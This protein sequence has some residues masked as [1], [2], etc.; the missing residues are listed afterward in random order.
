MLFLFKISLKNYNQNQ[1]KMATLIKTL[2]ALVLILT[3][4]VLGKVLLNFDTFLKFAKNYK[5]TISKV[6]QISNH[7]LCIKKNGSDDIEYQLDLSDTIPNT[8]FDFPHISMFQGNP[9]YLHGIVSLENIKNIAPDYDTLAAIFGIVNCSGNTNNVLKIT[10][11]K[12]AIHT[13]QESDSTGGAEYVFTKNGIFMQT[14]R[15]DKKGNIAYTISNE[16]GEPGMVL[17][18]NSNGDTAKWE[19]QSLNT[20]LLLL[21]Q[22]ESNKQARGAGLKQGIPYLLNTV[23]NGEHLQLISLTR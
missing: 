12:V 1:S 5:T 23:I 19:W 18:M 21:P 7:K 9:K 20:T 13:A 4:L 22:Y 11:K 8:E 3:L 6:N 14:F 15:D 16:K 17:T 10:P 2:T